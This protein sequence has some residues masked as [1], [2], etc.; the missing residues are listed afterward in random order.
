MRDNLL[1]QTTKIYRFTADKLRF[2]AVEA[3]IEHIIDRLFFNVPPINIGELIHGIRE[4]FTTIESRTY[5][6]RFYLFAI[7]HLQKK[8]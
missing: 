4:R 3:L 7:D 2:I 6:R 5:R 1:E 8:F